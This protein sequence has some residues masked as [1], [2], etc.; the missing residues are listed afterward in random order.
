M[1]LKKALDIIKVRKFSIF[2]YDVKESTLDDVPIL[3][4]YL[5]RDDNGK[6]SKKDIQFPNA[7]VTEIIPHESGC[8]VVVYASKSKGELL[9][10][11]DDE[12]QKLVKMNHD[13]WAKYSGKDEYIKVIK[14][15]SKRM[16]AE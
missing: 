6:I 3:I 1:K 13:E 15:I 7:K 2:V 8:N 5:E 12:V 11:L 14:Q 9:A 16:K 10:N 4:Y